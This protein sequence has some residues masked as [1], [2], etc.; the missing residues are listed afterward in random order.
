MKDVLY[1]L[2]A[3]KFAGAGDDIL[4]GLAERAAKNIMTEEDA[5]QYVENLT[6]GALLQSYGD[7]RATNATKGVLI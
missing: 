3:T 5:N 7:Q 2:L 6:I 1:Q 4:K